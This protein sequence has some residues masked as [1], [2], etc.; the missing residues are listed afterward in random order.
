MVSEVTQAIC[1]PEKGLQVQFSAGPGQLAFD[2]CLWLGEAR[3]IDC[4]R[5]GG[6]R[7]GMLRRDA[8]LEMPDI[9]G[10]E[11]TTF[12]LNVKHSIID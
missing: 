1:Q 2:F 9:R 8:H 6:G 11:P 3:M 5:V 4:E 10:F 7:V 12:Q